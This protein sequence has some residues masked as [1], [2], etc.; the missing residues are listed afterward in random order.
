MGLTN[1]PSTF[2]RVMNYV[3]FDLLADFVIVYLDNILI[4][5]KTRED[6][7]TALNKV[8]SRFAIFKLVLK[9][10]K[11]ALFLKSVMFLGYVISAE[12]KKQ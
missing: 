9:E 12:G 3:F 1:T 10:S 6:Y 4:L 7:F 8:F 5:S 11:Y 2:L